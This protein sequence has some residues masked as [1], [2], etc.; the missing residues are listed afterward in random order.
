MLERV[1]RLLV[2]TELQR[3][4]C[5]KILRTIMEKGYYPVPSQGLERKTGE[6]LVKKGVLMKLR[7]D[8]CRPMYAKR[9]IK[10]YTVNLDAIH[11][12]YE[13]LHSLKPA[14]LCAD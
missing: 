13:V 3:Q 1:C 7:I 2:N 4:A 14:P 6:L 9:S 12:L 10:V 11:A 8:Y 5:V